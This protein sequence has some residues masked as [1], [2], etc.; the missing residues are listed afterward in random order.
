MRKRLKKKR[1]MVVNRG[2]VYFRPT[3]QRRRETPYDAFVR[4]TRYIGISCGAAVN[5]FAEAFYPA[6]DD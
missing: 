1:G 6:K 4:M 3:R 5:R 2:R